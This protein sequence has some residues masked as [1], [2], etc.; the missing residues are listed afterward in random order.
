MIWDVGDANPLHR[1]IPGEVVSRRQPR[2]VKK[3][4]AE[5]E[6]EEVIVDLK[7]AIAL[8]PEQRLKWLTK[9][10]KMMTDDLT[11]STELFDIVVSRKFVAGMPERVVRKISAV[12]EDNMEAFSDKQRRYLASTE[13]P[14]VA[15][16]TV[17]GPVEPVD[18]GNDEAADADTALDILGKQPKVASDASRKL[19]LG[20]S[21]LVGERR[22]QP[23]Q[24]EEQ[25]AGGSSS[26]AQWTSV[27]D[28][29]A[30]RR[31]D[32]ERKDREKQEETKREERR[33]QKLADEL[34]HAKT[35]EQEEDAR[36]RKLE[37]EADALF[38]QAVSPPVSM[39]IVPAETRNKSLSRSRSIS[40]RTARRMARENK[41]AR[42]AQKQSHWRKDAGRSTEL[43]GSRA[44]FMNRDFVEDL[45]HL[46][47]PQTPGVRGVGGNVRRASPEREQERSRSRP[48]RRR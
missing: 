25:A 10:C 39:D 13:C 46:A 23:R 35:L 15:R 8:K 30:I 21:A 18:Y 40:S 3:P 1:R 32:A 22:Q 34:A 44:I 37:E 6:P 11:S 48:R 19:L 43:S 26:D 41:A 5:K 42:Q 47:R 33:K 27:K 9:A 2:V 7:A 29:W 14:I 45:P 17:R 36:R 20:T 4:V 16:L 24:P 28:E 38:S 31:Q 12:L